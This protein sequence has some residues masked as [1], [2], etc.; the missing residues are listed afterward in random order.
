MVL[1]SNPTRLYNSDLDKEFLK[2]WKLKP[3]QSSLSDEDLLDQ[4]LEQHQEVIKDQKDGVSRA[5]Q[6]FYLLVHLGR[7]RRTLFPVPDVS[8][9]MLNILA[10]RHILHMSR[11]ICL[12]F[13]LLP[14]AVLASGLGAKVAPP[15]SP[16]YNSW[17]NWLF[18]ITR[19]NERDFAGGIILGRDPKKLTE[20]DPDFPS[21]ISKAAGG[22][23]FCLCDFLGVFHHHGIRNKWLEAGVLRTILQLPRPRRQTVS[24]YPAIIETGDVQPGRIRLASI[25]DIG[26]GPG[27]LS[28]SEVLRVVFRPPDRRESLD[29]EPKDLLQADQSDFTPR[30][31]LVRKEEPE[32]LPLSSFAKVIRCQFP[33]TRVISEGLD[34]NSNICQEVILSDLDKRTGFFVEGQGQKVK[35]VAPGRQLY[36]YFFKKNDI[37]ISNR[38]SEAHIG[39]VGF[40]AKEPS[41]F[42]IC[43]LSVCIIRVFNEDV[44]PVWLYYYLRRDKVRRQILGYA[45]GGRMLTVNIGDLGKL[46]IPRPEP[47]KVEVRNERHAR[48][49]ARMDVII[50]NYLEIEA[51]VKSNEEED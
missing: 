45:T 30:R 26:P 24:Y 44:D 40:V 18:P 2:Y 36:K 15:P 46:P 47:H 4:A 7:Y 20:D 37:L 35:F 10:A 41:V 39:R 34:E 50:N 32:D 21:S 33:R 12:D 48:I 28:Q 11:I 14:I 1:M 17:P 38:S 6:L 42:A 43:G 3:S 5:E 51:D 16:N 25:Q 31:Y 8:L 9:A 13:S 19:T 27:G 29:V 22:L 49:L 23:F